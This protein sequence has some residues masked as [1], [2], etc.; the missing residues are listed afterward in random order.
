MEFV[1]GNPDLVAVILRGET[2]VGVSSTATW[3]EAA[4]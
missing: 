1:L 4:L 3:P 2:L